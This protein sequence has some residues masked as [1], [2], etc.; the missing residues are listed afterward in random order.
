VAQSRALPIDMIVYVR[1]HLVRN[2]RDRGASP[3]EIAQ[4]QEVLDP[5][6]LTIGFARRFAT[7]K[8]ATLWMRDVER[9]KRIL[10]GNKDRKVQFV[11]SGKAHPKDVRVKN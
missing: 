10:T 2:L 5:S 11:F 3:A 6:V 9:L 4:A 8:Q 1:E 7:Y